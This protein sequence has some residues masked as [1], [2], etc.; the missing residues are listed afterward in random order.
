MPKEF[1]L[2]IC[3]LACICCKNNARGTWVG[4]GH[5]VHPC[6]IGS[7]GREF[8]WSSWRVVEEK[9]FEYSSP[10]AMRV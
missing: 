9:V 4:G 3:F 7:I 5:A 2:F 8:E 6:G 1:P 10:S